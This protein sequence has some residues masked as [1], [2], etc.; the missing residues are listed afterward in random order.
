MSH[1]KRFFDLRKIIQDLTLSETANQ[2]ELQW[3]TR[4]FSKT[5]NR[6]YCVNP[7]FLLASDGLYRSDP[8]GDVVGG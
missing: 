1:P 3:Y 7:F 6:V 4:I 2:I 5:L 8:G